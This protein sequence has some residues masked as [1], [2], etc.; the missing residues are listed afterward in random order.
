MDGDQYP[1]VLQEASKTA[2]LLDKVAELSENAQVQQEVLRHGVRVLIWQ[3]CSP[4]TLAR[5]RPASGLLHG[6]QQ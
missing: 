5:Y 6:V 3:I 2:K 4:S 1:L